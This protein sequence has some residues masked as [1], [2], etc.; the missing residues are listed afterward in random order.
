[1]IL[2]QAAR[3]GEF[4]CVDALSLTFSHH[5]LAVLPPSSGSNMMLSHSISLLIVA[6]AI[7]QQCVFEFQPRDINQM[8]HKKYQLIDTER[9]QK[10]GM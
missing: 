10:H 8:E 3:S 5:I 9:V 7:D 2:R 6:L 4:S 1:M